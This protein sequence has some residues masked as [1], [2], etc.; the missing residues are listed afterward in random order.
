MEYVLLLVARRLRFIPEGGA[1]VEV[2]CRTVQ[3]RLL[4]KPSEELNSI[5]LGVLARAQRLYPV[6]IHAFVFLSNHYHLLLSVENAQKLAR[7]M[8]YLNSN[9]AREVGRL[10]HWRERFWGRR[11]QAIVVSEE[12]AAQVDR[13]IYILSHGCKEGLVARPQEWPGAHSVKAL[14]E[15]CEL[16]GWWLDRTREHAAR[17][18]RERFDRRKFATRE[19]IR[20]EPL[21]CWRHLPVQKYR[22]RVLELVAQIVA[23]TS[24]RHARKGTQPIGA[25]AVVAQNPHDKSSR[26]K[27]SSAPA[28]HAIKRA[29]RRDLVEAYSMFVGAYREAAE[30]LRQGDLAPRFPIGVFLQAFPLSGG[31]LT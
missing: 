28:F 9:L 22:G 15:G 7:F 2:T 5:V 10:N 12:E 25:E 21:P 29:V 19:T 16:E 3:G 31:R 24:D 14:V 4:L 23:V 6:D 26:L 27:K 8:N 30:R 20:V 18:G 1:L 17:A 13:L 11:Y